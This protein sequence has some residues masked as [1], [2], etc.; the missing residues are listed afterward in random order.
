MTNDPLTSRPSPL[1]FNPSPLPPPPLGFLPSIV[2]PRAT[3][4]DIF[5]EE[6][7]EEVEQ[8]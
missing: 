2:S 1:L 4:S 6:E 7:E 3:V 8:R 5:R